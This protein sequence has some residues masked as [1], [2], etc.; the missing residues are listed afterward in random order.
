MGGKK[1]NI[2]PALNL[3]CF[4]SFLIYNKDEWFKYDIVM[5]LL[6]AHINGNF[7]NLLLFKKA[8]GA[9]IAS[10]N[11]TGIVDVPAARWSNVR[12]RSG[13]HVMS[14]SLSSVSHQINQNTTGQLLCRPLKQH[15]RATLKTHKKCT[16]AT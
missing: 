9:V 11:H 8:S 14:L 12:V 13:Q 7:D 1:E 10:I 5:S 3:F 16:K 6:F 4:Y 15:R 2:W